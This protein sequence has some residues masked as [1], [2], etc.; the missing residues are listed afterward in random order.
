MISSL[1]DIIQY[2]DGPLMCG[3]KCEETSFTILRQRG[4]VL[5]K[6]VY[7]TREGALL[8]TSHQFLILELNRH[9]KRSVVRDIAAIQKSKSLFLAVN[10]DVATLRTWQVEIYTLGIC[11]VDVFTIG[12]RR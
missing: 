10:M 12:C 3:G 9:T 11:C 1:K 4:I 2:C 6:R 5:T 8:N 7:A